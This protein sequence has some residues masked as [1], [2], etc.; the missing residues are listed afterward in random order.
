MI[1]FR[2]LLKIEAAA[3][4]KNAANTEAQKKQEEKNKTEFDE[5]LPAVEEAVGAAEDAVEAVSI[6]AAPIIND[7]PEDAGASMKKVPHGNSHPHRDINVHP[8]RI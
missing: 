6:M 2:I 1:P 4:A 5:A 7:P 3:K 8:W